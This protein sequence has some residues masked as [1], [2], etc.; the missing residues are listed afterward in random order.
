MNE[1]LRLYLHHFVLA[2]FDNI[3]VYNNSW[4]EHLQHV[5]LIL[6]TLKEH[7]LAHESNKSQKLLFK[8]AELDCPVLETGSSGFVG[9]DDSRGCHQAWTRGF[10]SSK[11]S[12]GRWR[13]KN[14]GKSRS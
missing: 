5:R 3:L 10:S 8:T 1:V 7:R 11:M 14:N 12:Y 6:A 9:T 2:F 4:S 13:G